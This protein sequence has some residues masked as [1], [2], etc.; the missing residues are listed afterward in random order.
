MKMQCGAELL[1]AAAYRGHP[2]AFRRR[3]IHAA[4]FC[5]DADAA[6]ARFLAGLIKRGHKILIV[7][8][9][10]ELLQERRVG[11]RC[12]EA[13]EERFAAGFLGDLREIA[14]AQAGAEEVAA[15]EAD[16]ARKDGV[17]DDAGT[18]RASDGRIEI[19]AGW[20]V[21]AEAVNSIGYQEHLAASAGFGP[22]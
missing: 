14:L 8:N 18:L 5:A 15:D 3:D 2:P 7:E 22:A 16:A 6:Q 4:N 9:E 19:R 17:D 13:L 20:K 12:V 11:D 21:A 1:R 10:V